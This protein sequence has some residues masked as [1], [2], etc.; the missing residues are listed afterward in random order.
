[1]SY[2]LWKDNTKV[3]Y[4]KDIGHIAM[5]WNSQADI[6][7]AKAATVGVAI[8]SVSLSMAHPVHQ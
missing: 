5:G 8:H 2:T 4:L 3:Q 6:I 7:I 1:M